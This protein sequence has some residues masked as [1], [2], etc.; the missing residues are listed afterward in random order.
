MTTGLPA[1]RDGRDDQGQ[2]DRTD[3]DYQSVCRT[4]LCLAQN[5]YPCGQL[6]GLAWKTAH[7]SSSEFP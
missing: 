5:V 4:A 2:D 3:Y 6:L 7:H 1:Q